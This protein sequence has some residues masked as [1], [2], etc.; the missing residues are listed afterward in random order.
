MMKIHPAVEDLPRSMDQDD[1]IA[2]IRERGQQVPIVLYEGM[3]W[4]GRARFHAAKVLGLNPWIVPLRGMSPIQFYIQAN[5]R[6]AGE[7]QSLDRRALIDSLM[8]IRARD[9]KEQIANKWSAWLRAARA[10]FAR[11]ERGARQPCAVCGRHTEFVHAHH[12]LPLRFQLECGVEE[13]IHDYDWLCPVHHKL[14][15]VMLSGY[16]LDAAPLDFL[17]N[18]AD[19]VIDEW[20]AIERVA[21]RGVNLCCEVLGRDDGASKGRYDPP[22]A[23]YVAK[24]QHRLFPWPRATA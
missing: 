15:H 18:L 17:D 3:I 8:H 4:D 20:L 23:L 14:V 16:L 12:S 2:D 11:E 24:N 5:Y 10:E 7:P 1:L 6:R 22:F 19:D 21:Q 9:H 13:P